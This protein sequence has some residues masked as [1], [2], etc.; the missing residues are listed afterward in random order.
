MADTMTDEN[1]EVLLTNE[2]LDYIL[3]AATGRHNVVFMDQTNPDYLAEITVAVRAMVNRRCGLE[4]EYGMLDSRFN[5]SLLNYRE[6]G[7]LE[8]YEGGGLA[9]QFDCLDHPRMVSLSDKMNVR[10]SYGGAV[11]CNGETQVVYNCLPGLSGPWFDLQWIV[12]CHTCQCGMGLKC[13]EP[14]GDV[15][16]FQ[17]KVR[18][19]VLPSA[20]IMYGP[21]GCGSPCRFRLKFIADTVVRGIQRLN[22]QVTRWNNRSGTEIQLSGLSDDE[23]NILLGYGLSPDKYRQVVLVYRT[24]CAVRSVYDPELMYDAYDM[25]RGCI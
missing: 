22:G 14:Y 12:S 1:T 16:N 2:Q 10:T 8:R 4:G 15:V 23:R 24:L 25:V 9:V 7:I 11:Q 6:G 20:E 19:F 21:Y 5:P 3:V 18:T 17:D 13:H